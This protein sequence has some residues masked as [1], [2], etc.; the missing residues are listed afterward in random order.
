VRALVDLIFNPPLE[1]VDDDGQV[2]EYIQVD[3]RA[4][5]ELMKPHWWYTIFARKLPCGCV[6]RW[7]GTFTLYVHDC[8]QHGLSVKE[9]P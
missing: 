9:T 4:R 8:P 1:A 6:R 3:R 7:W 2:I 5:L